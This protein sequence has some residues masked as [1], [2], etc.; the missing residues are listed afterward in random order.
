MRHGFERCKMET[1]IRQTERVDSVFQR[2]LK[3]R[4]AIK[5]KCGQDMEK[6]VLRLVRVV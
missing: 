5:D 4:I 2:L 1:M 6:G 3:Q